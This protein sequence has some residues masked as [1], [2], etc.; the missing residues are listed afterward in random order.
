MA[1]N[2]SATKKV[3]MASVKRQFSLGFNTPFTLD[4]L[5]LFKGCHS[6]YIIKKKKKKPKL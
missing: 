3:S 6:K 4:I 2:I 5:L 1:N